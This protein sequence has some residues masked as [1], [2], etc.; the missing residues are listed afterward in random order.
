MG[1]YLKSIVFVYFV[2][3]AM[4]AHANF[5]ATLSEVLKDRLSALHHKDP[6]C[7]GF[8]IEAIT[9]P[10]EMEY[11]YLALVKFTGNP[12][13]CE[14]IH[15]KSAWKSLDNP[16]GKR[17]HLLRSECQMAMASYSENVNY[18]NGVVPICTP[19]LSGSQYNPSFCKSNFNKG[20]QV[21]LTGKQL[22]DFFQTIDYPSEEWVKDLHY[23]IQIAP[24]GKKNK[25][26]RR[27]NVKKKLTLLYWRKH[28]ELKSVLQ[29]EM[30][31]R[32]VRR[33]ASHKKSK[34]NE[35]LNSDPE[36]FWNLYIQYVVPSYEF[37][38]LIYYKSGKIY[39]FNTEE[40]LGT[41]I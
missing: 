1:I 11:T 31:F 15:R 14:K 24:K 4:P 12:F 18:C 29:A 7:D 37:A 10:H 36:S 25:V 22:R 13:I 41:A 20:E 35:M 27:D 39:D 38:E 17:I 9:A 16:K 30:R 3:A 34:Y 33:P 8:E 6:K 19:Y 40:R 32:S 5:M 28:Q 26:L 2:V 23:Q 21:N